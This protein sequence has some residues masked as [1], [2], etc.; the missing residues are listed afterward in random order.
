LLS[1]S[2][3]RTS[4]PAH[5]RP[6]A[7]QVRSAKAIVRWYLQ[8][9]FGTDDDP[10][11][12]AMFADRRRVGSFAVDPIG[13]AAGRGDDLF[14]LLVATTMFQR[15]QDVQILRI[16]RSLRREDVHELTRPRRLLALVDASPCAHIRETATLHETCNLAKDPISRR[17]SCSANPKVS[18]H[19]KRHTVLLRRYGHFG[20][21]PT[22]AALVLRE[23]GVRDLS[24]LRL[25][26][27]AETAEPEARARLLEESLSKAWRVSSKIA[28]MFLSALSA[29][30]L[31]PQPPWRDGID[32]TRFVVVDS[33]VDLCLAALGYAGG[34]SYDARREFVRGIARRIDLAKVRRGL[35]SFNPRLVQQA[36]YVF[37]SVTNRRA[38]PRDCMHLGAAACARCPA[39]VAA[40]CPTRSSNR[41]RQRHVRA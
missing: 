37:M 40:I 32:W 1:L 36:M 17:G 13:L 27:M 29:P 24:A 25:K 2:A 9:Y 38:V 7:R 15:R 11:V 20:K 26:I 14:R 18:C 28:S 12:P 41:E 8:L 19:M 33:N 30:D 10:G 39:G 5:V 3:G 4:R 22:S 31:S 34:S 6:T 23:A 35:T 21:V 16:L